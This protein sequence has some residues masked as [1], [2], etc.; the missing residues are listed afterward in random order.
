MVGH[1]PRGGVQKYSA[2]II[3][4][5]NPERFPTLEG[6]QDLPTSE[7]NTDAKTVG[8]P[9]LSGAETRRGGGSH[10]FLLRRA[11]F[12]PLLVEYLSGNLYA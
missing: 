7:S 2:A 12:V 5:H 8:A 9:T 4:P 10:S 6:S 3:R 11:E 1:T